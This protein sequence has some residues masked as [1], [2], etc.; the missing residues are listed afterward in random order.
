[1][2]SLE[3]VHSRQPTVACCELSQGTS[4]NAD[5]YTIL[6]ATLRFAVI[7]LSHL[8]DHAVA[9]RKLVTVGSSGNCVK[10]QLIR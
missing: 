4:Q 2:K 1:M 3:K 5:G 9:G 7:S 8:E 10:L 6:C